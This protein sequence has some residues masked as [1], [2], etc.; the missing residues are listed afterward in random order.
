MYRGKHT[1]KILK[2][3]RRQIAEANDIEY[4]TSECR[5]QGDCLGTC[6]KC[7]AEVRYLEQQLEKK[8]LAGKAATLIGVSMGIASLTATVT[9]SAQTLKPILTET[10]QTTDSILIKG[11]IKDAENNLIIGANIVETGTNNG[12]LSDTNGNFQLNVSGKHPLTISYIGYQTQ[13]V[14]VSDN[15]P[16]QIV[17]ETSDMLIGECVVNSVSVKADTA[18]VNESDEIFPGVI[19]EMPY[20]PGGD[21]AC[22]RYIGKHLRYPKKAKK[23]G[24]EGRVLI[25]FTV[26][27]DGTLTDFHVVRGIE[28]SLD[29]EALRLVKSMPKWT[30]G[31]Q[32]GVVVNIKYTLPI[33]FRLDK[34][35]PHK[36]D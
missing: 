16:L 22:M 18:T 24:I 28:E 6:P 27:K 15:T 12:T 35:N 3:I 34:E 31:K 2:E 25:Q 4:I 13:V 1:C 10:L 9:A 32:R 30:P 29:R 14:K 8:R 21:A 23:K 5:Y 26:N 20:F 17:L 36:E 7:E 11:T 19:E 33:R